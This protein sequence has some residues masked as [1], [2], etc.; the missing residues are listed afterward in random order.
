MEVMHGNQEALLTI[1]QVLLYDPLYAWTL[2]PLKAYNLQHKADPDISQLNATTGKVILDDE[3][4]DS[5]EEDGSRQKG[6]L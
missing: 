2:S 5:D 6:Q 1:L 4:E 3:E